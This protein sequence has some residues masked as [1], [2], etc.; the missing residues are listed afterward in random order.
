MA[1][2][3]YRT[4]LFD[5]DGTVLDSIDMIKASLR[6]ALQVHLDWEPADAVL[7]RGVGT[8]LREQLWLHAVDAHEA[9]GHGEPPDALV[10]ELVA[11]YLTHN[12][13][14][15]D[16]EIRPFPD[17]LATLTTMAEAG[18]ALGIVTSKPHETARRGLRI[19]GLEHLFAVVVGA[20]DVRRPKPDPE[21]VHAALA[22]LGATVEGALFVGDSPHDL[23]AGRAAGVDTAAALW[24]PFP[25]EALAP[26]TPSHWVETLADL[27][28]LGD[29]CGRG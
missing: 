27:L 23:H 24:G 16:A 22:A 19:A 12:R 13:A 5:L 26:A 2:R 6:H 1:L 14:R 28:A 15:H 11:A 4:V 9:R 18:L 7:V 25:R 17:A 8:P 10:D 29:A 3:R 21:P 20:D